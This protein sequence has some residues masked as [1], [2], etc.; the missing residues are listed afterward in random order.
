MEYVNFIHETKFYK[1]LVKI[2]KVVKE[3][4]MEIKDVNSKDNSEIIENKEIYNFPSSNREFE[5]KKT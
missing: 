3:S 4:D 1:I 5:T 2:F